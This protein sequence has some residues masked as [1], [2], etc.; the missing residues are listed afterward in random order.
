MSIDFGKNAGLY[1]HPDIFCRRVA[2]H[3]SLK[4]AAISPHGNGPPVKLH[5][6][7]RVI[8]VDVQSCT[9]ILENGSQV[10]G[11]CIIGADGVKVIL[12]IVYSSGSSITYL[13]Q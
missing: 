2:I 8:D 9:L 7:S 11:D 3:N 5:T 12:H 10:S 6:S 13:S 1:Q 4:S